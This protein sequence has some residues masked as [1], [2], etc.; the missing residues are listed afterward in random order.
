MENGN[1]KDPNPPPNTPEDEDMEVEYEDSM[2]NSVLGLKNVNE[3][4]SQP[5]ETI[6]S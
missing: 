6:R 2:W 1:N 3:V 4:E 5:E